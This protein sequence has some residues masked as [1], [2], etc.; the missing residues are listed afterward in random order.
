[1]V[2]AKPLMVRLPSNLKV[3]PFCPV[4]DNF[5]LYTLVFYMSDTSS[6]HDEEDPVVCLSLLNPDFMDG[7]SKQ[8]SIS[9]LN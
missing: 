8:V 2:Q 7:V 1:M 9:M 5:V 4:A 6:F 3:F